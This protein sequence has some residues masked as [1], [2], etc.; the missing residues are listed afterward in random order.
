MRGQAAF[1]ETGDELCPLEQMVSGTPGS[2]GTGLAP[3]PKVQHHARREQ[4]PALR[5]TDPMEV[6]VR[7][8]RWGR[9]EGLMFFASSDAQDA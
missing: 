9:A 5:T 8:K 3:R 2:T 6:A 7:P 4:H 1:A